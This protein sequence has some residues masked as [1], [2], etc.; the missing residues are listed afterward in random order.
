[1][2]G[3]TQVVLLAPIKRE[4]HELGYS[5]L[6]ESTRFPV[7]VLFLSEPLESRVHYVKSQVTLHFK[8]TG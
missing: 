5:L 7:Q 6:Y 1:M 4:T 3:P 8:F 2:G